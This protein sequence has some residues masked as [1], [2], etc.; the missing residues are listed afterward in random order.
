VGQLLEVLARG[1]VEAEQMQGVAQVQGEVRVAGG[2]ELADEENDLPDQLPED[3]LETLELALK[4][5]CNLAWHDCLL[6]QKQEDVGA[7]REAGNAGMGSLGES[8]VGFAGVSMEELMRWS[9]LLEKMRGIGDSG[10]L[11][12]SDGALGGRARQLVQKLLLG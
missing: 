4:A 10:L 2:V 1:L 5:V 12:I 7:A 9:Q 11:M 3:V 6:K 8:C